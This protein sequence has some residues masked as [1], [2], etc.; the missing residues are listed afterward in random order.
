MRAEGNISKNVQNN[1]DRK[2]IGKTMRNSFLAIILMFTVVI[3][4]AMGSISNMA[5][6]VRT[7]ENTHMVILNDSWVARRNLIVYQN[8]LYKMC[9]AKEKELLTQYDSEMQSCEKNYTESLEGIKAITDEYNEEI[10]KIESYTKDL[11]KFQK[12]IT[13]LI[14]EGNVNEAVMMLDESF[15]PQADLINEQLLAI[16]ARV[17]KTTEEYGKLTTTIEFGVIAFMIV[18]LGAASVTAVKLAKMN[19][20]K[21]AEPLFA[22]EGAMEQMKVGNLEFEL[23]YHSENELGHTAHALRSTRRELH[24]Y[25]ENIDYVLKSL[26][27]KNFDVG[28]ETE[29][30]GMFNDIKQSLITIIDS[31]NQSLRVI[32]TASLG[33]ESESC[34]I[35]KVAQSLAE[36]AAEQA[37]TVEELLATVQNVSEQVKL[38][39]ESVKEVSSRAA[40]SKETVDTGNRHMEELVGAMED[41]SDSS[42]RISE[43]LTVIEGISGQ[44]NMLAL[45]ASI[46]AARAGEAGRGFAVVAGEIGELA[47]KTREATKTTEELINRSLQAVQTGNRIVM[48]TAELLR[49]VVDSTA[50][51]TDLAENVAAASETQA[52]SLVQIE[53]AVEQISGVVQSN[54]GLA[55]EA[56]LSS[57]EL[58]SHVEN[59]SGIINEFKLKK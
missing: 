57:E 8:S 44:T 49:Q 38:N 10:D 19:M 3:L 50:V 29:Y 27:V 25:I 59:L 30:R 35:E 5:N 36:G 37:G 40:K 51:I 23:E 4:C 21:I 55:Q 6:R 41:I 15:I 28:V 24:K 14:Y 31:L 1:F 53:G 16:A 12:N 13:G 46:E 43:I 48:T 42:S 32:K 47:S 56:A 33:V 20:K 18:I 22:I 26:S 11:L 34:Q 52:E 9:L 17:S 7:L 2:S 45:N 54:T 39:A 58:N